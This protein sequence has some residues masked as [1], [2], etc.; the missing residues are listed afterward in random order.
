MEWLL[1]LGVFVAVW[2]GYYFVPCWKDGGS[3]DR[4][5]RRR[6]EGEVPPCRE[7]MS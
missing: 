7:G 6:S 4:S 1:G 5:T 2:F 3:N